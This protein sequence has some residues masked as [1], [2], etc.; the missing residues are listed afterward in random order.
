MTGPDDSSTWWTAARRPRHPAAARMQALYNPAPPA[1]EPDPEPSIEIGDLASYSAHRDELLGS[2]TRASD[3][4]GVDK[5]VPRYAEVPDRPP[6]RSAGREFDPDYQQA[7]HYAA[8]HTS[9]TGP[10]R[11]IS[12][13]IES[14]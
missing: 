7:Q 5:W 13:T 9:L 1:P 6:M 10:H 4:Q 8:G 12:S 14:R 11:D 2:V 3:F